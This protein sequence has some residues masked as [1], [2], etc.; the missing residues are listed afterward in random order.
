MNEQ[1]VELYDMLAEYRGH[2]EEVEHPEDIQNVIDSVLAALTNEDSIDPDE[3]ELI[4]AYIED[5]DQGYSDYEELMETIKDYQE[6]L[7]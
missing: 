5:F 4:A 2:L 3:L 7:H 6:R 1:N